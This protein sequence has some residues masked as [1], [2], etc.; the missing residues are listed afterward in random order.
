MN[1]NNSS[2][3]T[4]T[5]KEEGNLEKEPVMAPSSPSVLVPGKKVV[6]RP[7]QIKTWSKFHRFPKC[8]DSIIAQKGRGGYKTGLTLEEQHV[9]EDA[10]R[11]PVGELHS[12]SK[13]WEEH[14]FRLGEKDTVLDMGIPI[15]Y[16]NLKLAEQSKKVAKSIAKK[17]ETPKAE[18]VIFDIVDDARAEN[19]KIEN[20]L[21]AATIFNKMSQAEQVDFLKLLGRRATHTQPEVIKNQL[22]KEMEL[23][24]EKFIE[25]AELPDR[26]VRVLINDLIQNNILR[27]QGGHYMHGTISIGYDLNAAVGYLGDPQNQDLRVNLMQQLESAKKIRY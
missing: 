2:K 5:T 11:L 12:N 17:Y 8:Q 9:L 27:L 14:V 20:K 21:K 13:F 1:K 24:P 10:M 3:T 16:I 25:I 23:D 4:N 19:K 7:L 15:D 6:I 18:Y 26:D 22:Y